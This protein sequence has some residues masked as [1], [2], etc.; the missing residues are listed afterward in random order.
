[1]YQAATDSK[2]L[3]GR[4]AEAAATAEGE[5]WAGGKQ[6]S[7]GAARAEEF[8]FYHRQIH[9]VAHKYGESLEE[10]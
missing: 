2:M 9:A 3:A 5:D 1:M 4:A 8:C 7:A 10:S 6:V